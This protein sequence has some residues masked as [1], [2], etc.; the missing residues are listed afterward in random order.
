MTTRDPRHRSRRYDGAV[1]RRQFV[2]WTIWGVRLLAG[3]TVLLSLLLAVDVALPGTAE[4][5][6]PYRRS[7]DSRWLVQ[8]GY[9]VSVGW[10]HRTGCV[11]QD[12]RSGDQFLFTTRPGCSG[13]VAVSA[14]FGAQL[15]RGDTVRV[16]RTPL[17]RRVRT[18]QRP[19]A[20]P[21]ASWY[22][23][24]DVGLFV[25]LGLIPLLSFGEGFAVYAP[26]ADDVRY[27]VVYVLPALVAEALYV[28][29][30]VQALGGG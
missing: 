15:A 7:V 30:V 8:D 25:V 23:L 26:A 6:I 12:D 17:F 14:R 28:W 3:P 21:E 13:S 20:N 27:H 16:V 10:P 22:P 18:V 1:R 24:L 5:G 11:E 9:T 19:G 2:R 29:L 4:E